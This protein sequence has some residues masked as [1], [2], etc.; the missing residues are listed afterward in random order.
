MLDF[1]GID[2]KRH[3]ILGKLPF[4]CAGHFVCIKIFS[5]T[6]WKFKKVQEDEQSIAK[7]I[8]SM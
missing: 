1:V 3:A 4:L 2:L 5:A 8:S 6:D 7:S